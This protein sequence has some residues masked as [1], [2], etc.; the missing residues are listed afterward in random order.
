MQA[1]LAS[2]VANCWLGLRLE[3]IAAAVAALFAALCFAQRHAPLLLARLAGA[4]SSAGLRRLGGLIARAA[5]RSSASPGAY[6]ALG[7][8][9][10]LQATQSLTWSVRQASELEAHMVSVERLQARC[11]PPP[12]PSPPPSS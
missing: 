3:L 10:A 9:L 4:L 2:A 5:A 12:L 8:T 11:L 1:S 6:G 7:L